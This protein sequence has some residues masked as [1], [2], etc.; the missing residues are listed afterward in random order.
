MHNHSCENE[1]NRLVN[2]GAK[3]VMFAA[4]LPFRH[5][6]N[7]LLRYHVF[8]QKLTLYFIGVYIIN[9]VIQ[10]NRREDFIEPFS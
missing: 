1:L 2:Q 7:M 8:V 9:A 5:E 10:S 3:K 6:D 4:S